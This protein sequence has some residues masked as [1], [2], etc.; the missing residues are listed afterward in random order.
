MSGRDGLPV[1]K[2][3]EI[4]RGTPASAYFFTL[5]PA[6]IRPEREGPDQ[7]QRL[8][9]ILPVFFSR[10]ITAVLNYH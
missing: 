9:M 3:L 7:K 8:F 1:T 2:R 4:K 5:R 6:R 10:F